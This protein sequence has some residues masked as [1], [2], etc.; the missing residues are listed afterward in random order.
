VKGYGDE[1]VCR[2]YSAEGG[3]MAKA[4]S[5]YKGWSRSADWRCHA[6]RL[7]AQGMQAVTS[8]LPSNRDRSADWSYD[9]QE[10][11]KAIRAAMMSVVGA[12][13]SYGGKLIGGL[14]A[15]SLVDPLVHLGSFPESLEATTGEE[16]LYLAS[17]P[18]PLFPD[19]A[20]V[21]LRD[22]WITSWS[23]WRR[24]ALPRI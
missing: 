20:G 19:E 3:P 5:V 14:A 13:W 9:V 4:T 22:D 16:P 10:A 8:D 21:V 2:P 23:N 6:A 11:K 7:Q 18:N 15:T 1:A 24:C 17:I 12:G